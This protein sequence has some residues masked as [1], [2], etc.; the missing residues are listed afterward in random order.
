MDIAVVG[1]GVAVTLDGKGVMVLSARVAL[2]AVA[3]VPLFVLQA[4]DWL[5]GRP[6]SVETIEAAA[7]MAQ[8][9]ARPIDDLRG[10]IG[11]R[12]QLSYVL[13]RRALEKAVARAKEARG[14]S[15][16]LEVQ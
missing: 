8:E 2:G 6:A 12:K 15:P 14:L 13:T 10:T 3:P 1:A 5:T 11:Q 16:A 7:R 9:A 4:G